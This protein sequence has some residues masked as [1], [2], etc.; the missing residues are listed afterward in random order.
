[1]NIK[2]L[3]QRIYLRFLNYQINYEN[4]FSLTKKNYFDSVNNCTINICRTFFFNLFV[5]VSYKRLMKKTLLFLSFMLFAFTAFATGEF[6]IANQDTN[7]VKSLNLQAYEARQSDPAQTVAIA[8]KALALAQ[9]LNYDSGVAEAYRVTGVGQYYLNLLPEAIKSY[10][11]ALTYF[12][13]IGDLHGQA[14]V[15]NNIGNLYRDNEYDMALD[16]FEKSLSIARKI[17]DRSIIA[18]ADLNAGNVYSRK[19]SFNEALKYYDESQP[20]FVAL[21]DST[22]IIQ[23]S[24][25]RGV[26]YFNLNQLDKAEKLLLDANIEAKNHDL[27]ETVASIDLTLASLYIQQSKFPKAE[28][29]LSEGVTY[30][31]LIKDERLLHDFKLTN[32]QLEYKRKNYIAALQDLREVY[33]MESADKKAQLGAQIMLFEVKQKQEEQQNLAELEQKQNQY[34]RVR[35][36]GVTSVA[37]LLMVM[38]VL[39]FSNVKRK[40]KTN[41]QLTALNEEVSKQKDNLDRVN[42]HLEEIIDDRTKDLQIKNKKLSDYSSYLS[43]Q[44]RGPI[45][46]LKG[47]LNLE[48]EGLV[49]KAE[50]IVMMDKCVSEIDE[51]I[52]ETSEMMHDPKLM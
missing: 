20:L 7:R 51:K 4:N 27:S 24:Q 25:N 2:S 46:T 38:I 50:C 37:G 10:L 45:A 44:I 13:K 35:F 23:C 36:W 41:S 9:K 14:K 21:H 49:D 19:K 1:M 22:N 34:E 3:T 16:F 26:A 33:Q 31:T 43:H 52:I 32:Y 11:N 29:I 12:Q 30:S 18:S 39:L 40:A 15:Y 5:N 48:K 17:G 28:A 8:A 42:H 6:E 47:L